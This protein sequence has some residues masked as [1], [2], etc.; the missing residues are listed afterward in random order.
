V[1][2][3]GLSAELLAVGVIPPLRLA[4]PVFRT[5]DGSVKAAAIM[6]CI[7]AD[8]ADD[9]DVADSSIECAP[10]GPPSAWSELTKLCSLDLRG[11]RRAE[12]RADFAEGQERLEHGRVLQDR[13]PTQLSQFVFGSRVELHFHA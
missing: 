7:R 4:D 3:T 11:M 1:P 2:K 8:G 13:E 6:L 10:R 12:S 5:V 9:Q